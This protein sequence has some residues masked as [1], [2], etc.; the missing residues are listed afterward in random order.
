[1]GFFAAKARG[2]IVG[3]L[4]LHYKRLQKQETKVKQF[5]M[6]A[7]F[8][9]QTWASLTSPG[10]DTSHPGT[11]PLKWAE[12]KEVEE[13][14]GTETTVQGSGWWFVVGRAF[15]FWVNPTMSNPLNLFSFGF[16][17]F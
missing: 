16:M 6:V 5:H 3:L 10:T 14:K 8:S 4:G 13:E 12:E 17:P 7:V 1:M 2:I 15:G 9:A 11:L